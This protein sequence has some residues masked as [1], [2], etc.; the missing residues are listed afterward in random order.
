MP[1]FYVTKFMLCISMLPNLPL[2]YL[3]IE[4]LFSKIYEP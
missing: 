4:Y 3:A 2:F 1:T